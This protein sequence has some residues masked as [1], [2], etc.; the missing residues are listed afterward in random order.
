MFKKL[1]PIIKAILYGNF[2]VSFCAALLTFQTYFLLHLPVRFDYLVF[3]FLSTLFLYTIQRLVLAPDYAKAPGSERH[4]WIIRQRSLLIRICLLAVLGMVVFVIRAPFRFSL[5]LFLSGLFSCLYFLP[6]FRIRRLLGFKSAMVALVWA[7]VT[8][9][10][11]ILLV[12]SNTSHFLDQLTKPTIIVLLFERFFF[13]LALCVVFNI[14]DIEHDRASAVKTIPALYG[15]QA[16]KTAAIFCL[17]ISGF[18]TNLL[19]QSAFYLPPL[20]IAMGT[21]LVTTALIIVNCSKE[22]KEAYYLFAIDGMMG[23]QPIL[24]YLA[25]LMLPS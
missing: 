25:F 17:G 18:L 22:R 13:V 4:A 5:F 10:T 9:L 21:S 11:P 24:I 20:R 8:V 19:L 12:D 15:I 16:G 3:V 1:T 7:F 14:R 23:L 6:G 2:F